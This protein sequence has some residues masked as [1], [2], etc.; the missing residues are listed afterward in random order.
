ML[1]ALDAYLWRQ[2]P[3]EE[4]G[5]EVDH[6]LDVESLLQPSITFVGAWSGEQALG[7]GAVRRA[8]DG[9]GAFGEVKRMWVEP[10][11][12]G[13]RVGERILEQLQAVMQAEGVTRLFLETGNRQPEALRLY[14]RCGWKRCAAYAGY[15]AHPCNVFMEKHL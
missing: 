3:P 1:A 13:Q 9:Q 10:A 5:R 11:V 6:I 2:Y 12:R 7:C 8:S 15:Q 4:F 14:E